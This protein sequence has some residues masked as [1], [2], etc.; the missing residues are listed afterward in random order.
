[1]K[2][3]THTK[4]PW[5]FAI[6][7]LEP[8]MIEKQRQAGIEPIRTLTNEGQ[9]PI[10]GG[11][12]DDRRRVA[13]VDCQADYKRGQGYKAECAERDANARLIAAAPDLLEVSERML[14]WCEYWV[15]QLKTDPDQD[16]ITAMRAAIAKAKGETQ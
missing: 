2:E 1:M 14:A 6:Y 16:I 9:A 5:E 11:G 10:M 12:D 8:E 15:A 4:G 13:L 7:G 3:A